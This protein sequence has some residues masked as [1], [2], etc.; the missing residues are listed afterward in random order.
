L[1]LSVV[2]ALS[3]TLTCVSEGVGRFGSSES[4]ANG[5][6]GVRVP[7]RTYIK[8]LVT[9]SAIELELGSPLL[10]A[11]PHAGSMIEPKPIK[12][13]PSELYFS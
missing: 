7:G 5:G 11:D 3:S 9:A 4:T 1:P 12:R 10:D 2:V 8:V 13:A 6:T